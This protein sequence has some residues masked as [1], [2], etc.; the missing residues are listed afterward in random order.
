MKMSPLTLGLLALLAY[1][2]YQGK[3]RLADMLG[4]RQQ[5]GLSGG[6][7]TDPQGGG[8]GDLLGNIFGGGQANA[9]RG[10]NGNGR[11]MAPAG[12]P[13]Q[14]GGLG[15][16]LGGLLG[17]AAAGSV[18]SGGLGG[19]LEQFQQKGQGDTAQSWIGKGENR[20]ISSDELERAVGK[21]A[22]DELA[23]NSGRPYDD[24][25]SQLSSELPGA[26]DEIT[27]DGRIPSEEEAGRWV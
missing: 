19:L 5:P 10:A 14:Q 13:A 16:L 24:V 25:V 27:P 3:G 8:L 11:A 9:S 21:D 22:L 6:G 1:R 18:L 23:R 7:H 4:Q 20:S 2:T 12:A 26:I 17:G 15:G